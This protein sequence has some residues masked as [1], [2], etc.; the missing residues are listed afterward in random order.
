[1][2]APGPGIFI[3]TPADDAGAGRMVA[4]R[5]LLRNAAKFENRMAADSV[6]VIVSEKMDFVPAVGIM[7]R[8]ESSVLAGIRCQSVQSARVPIRIIVRR[9]LPFF[10]CC[11]ALAAQ[12]A[13][14]I[15][16]KTISRDQRNYR[17]LQAWTY[18]V[19]DR[20]E[21]LDGSGGVKKTDSTLDEVLYIG[22][23][24]YIH[25]LEKNGKPLPPDQAAK[26]Q[27]KLDKASA[28][29]D[30]M[31]DEE[32]QKRELQTEKEREKD[33]E[34]LRYLPDAF[35]FRLLGEEAINGR[36]AWRIA[37]SPV[38]AYNGKYAGLLKNLEGTLWIDKQDYEFVK[39]DIRAIHGFSI[40]L[41]L[42]SVSEGSHLYFENQKLSDGIWVTHRAGFEGAARVL[43]KHIR[44]NEAL[45]FSDF[46]KFQTD[47]RIVAT[48]Q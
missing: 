26:E 7:M 12:D 48:E 20:I 43:I 32:R 9:I 31:T 30:K 1:M 37:A 11:V 47:S 35:V 29:A 34:M 5:P 21:K 6:Y 22:G 17:E 25:P 46:R 4:D 33:R 36:A 19:S 42:A 23:K 39:G 45:V 28:E 13:K 18:K 38:P 44:E 15:V 14:Q 41:F 24:P 10:C 40:G 8:I 3:L 16:E 2:A 27:K